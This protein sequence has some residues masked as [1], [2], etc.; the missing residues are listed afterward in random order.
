[1]TAPLVA[2]VGRPNVGKSTLFNQLTRSRDALVADEPGLTRDRR[3]GFAP[4]GGRQVV[5]VDTG[6]IVPEAENLEKE[7]VRQSLHAI[8][9]AALVLL[10]VDARAGLT[11]EDQHV[12]DAL[13]QKAR[14]VLLVVNKAEGLDLATA[15]GDFFALGFHGPVCTAAVHKQGLDRLRD[16]ILD[17]LPPAEGNLDEAPEGTAED[18]IR[19]ALVGRP[20][21]GKSTL[22]NRLLKE[23]RAIASD[24]PGTTRDSIEVPLEW[25]GRHYRLIDTA[26]L[27]RRGK[28]QEMVEKFSAIK[29]LQAIESA[30]VV[31][32][33]MDAHAEV[34]AQDAR[35]LTEVAAAGKALVLG[36]NKWDG[37]SPEQRGAFESEVERKLAFTEYAAVQRMSG[38]HGSG[39]GELME[40]VH[41]AARV[42]FID[43]STPALTDTLEALVR[44]H[45]PPLVGGRRPKLRYAHQG[46]K[47]P[48]RIVIHGNQTERLPDSYKRYLVNGFREAFAL[49]GTPLELNFKTSDNPYKDRKNTLSERQYKRRQRMIKHDRSKR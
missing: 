47:N 45:A 27:R 48:P 20:N 25:E 28:V 31:V 15:A 22:F 30:H 43:L 5:L 42:A 36:L 6:G 44:K 3:Y 26:G 23:E 32:M 39:L 11:L 24:I 35:I 2:L 7:I 13:R 29:T 9:E 21:A 33:L 12:V 38:L 17:L 46:G 34:S 4:F 1:M 18:A 8:D 19:I 14:P 49:W 40:K 41:R 37:L 10:V 16:A